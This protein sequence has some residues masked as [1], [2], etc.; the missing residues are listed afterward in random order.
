MFTKACYPYRQL[1]K[2]PSIECKKKL[3]GSVIQ[4]IIEKSDKY[5]SLRISHSEQWAKKAKAVLSSHRISQIAYMGAANQAV[6]TEEYP[7]ED[8]VGI[9]AVTRG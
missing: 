2:L 8:A 6:E 3:G 9:T 4:Q 7:T 1:M 5:T